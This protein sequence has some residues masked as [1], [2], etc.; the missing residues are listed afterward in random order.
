MKVAVL[1]LVMLGAFAAGG[2]ALGE[3]GAPQPA[4]ASSFA[5][6]THGAARSYGAPIQ[7]RIL[8]HVKKKPRAPAPTGTRARG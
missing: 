3:P 8:S 7:P 2:I 6:R 1:T 4:R 5:P